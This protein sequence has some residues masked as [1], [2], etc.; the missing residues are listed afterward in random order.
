MADTITAMVKPVLTAVAGR[1]DDAGLSVTNFALHDKPMARGVLDFTQ[2]L[3]KS[4]AVVRRG[5]QSVARFSDIESAPSAWHAWQKLAAA[6]DDVPALRK[7]LAIAPSTA[8]V[9]QARMEVRRLET[10]I[11]ALRA[12]ESGSAE[13]VQIRRHTNGM[14]DALYALNKTAAGMREDARMFRMTGG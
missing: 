1:L 11:E 4:G 8:H 10:Q 5:R 14:L 3:E 13:W 12:S 2:E 7:Q 6:M 9:R